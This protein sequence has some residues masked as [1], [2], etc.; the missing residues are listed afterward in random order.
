MVN[1]VSGHPIGPIF[2]DKA[3]KEKPFCQPKL[4]NIPEERRP[5]L[6]RSGRL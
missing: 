3:V 5:D 4:R 1:D 6:H 2:K